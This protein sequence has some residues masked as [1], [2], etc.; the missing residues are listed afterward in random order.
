VNILAQAIFCPVVKS[1]KFCVVLQVHQFATGR[2]Q[3]TQVVRLIF[4]IVLLVQLIVLFVS[5]AVALFFVAS[6]VLSTLFKAKSVFT[7]L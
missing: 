3:V 2:V 4:V 5:V 7:S 1:T 6:L